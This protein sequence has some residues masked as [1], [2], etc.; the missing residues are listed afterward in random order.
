[1]KQRSMF[2]MDMITKKICPN[3]GSEDVYMIAGGMTG[4]WMC[5][6]CGHVGPVFEKEIIGSE[7]SG[8]KGT[9]GKMKG[10]EVGRKK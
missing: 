9:K 2:K 5:K 6:K 10:K 7:R 8:M 3:C 1:M 4:T